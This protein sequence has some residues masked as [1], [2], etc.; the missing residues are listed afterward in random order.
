MLATIHPK[1]QR[2]QKG[3][4]YFG[5][6]QLAGRFYSLFWHLDLPDLGTGLLCGRADVSEYFSPDKQKPTIIP[7]FPSFIL[8]RLSGATGRVGCTV[9]A[10]QR[11]LCLAYSIHHDLAV[12][13]K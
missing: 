1:R 10:A 7:L 11:P 3:M 8:T 9:M 12:Q 5:P 13:G 2:K 6:R 4:K